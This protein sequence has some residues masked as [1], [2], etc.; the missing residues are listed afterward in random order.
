MKISPVGCSNSIKLNTKNTNCSYA[1][2]P[3]GKCGLVNDVFQKSSEISFGKKTKDAQKVL[4]R[5]GNNITGLKNE[6]EAAKACYDDPCVLEGYSSFAPCG[7]SD[8]GYQAD[9]VVVRN[10]NNA[11]KDTYVGKFACIFDTPMIINKM[12]V[13][14]DNSISADSIVLLGNNGETPGGII[15][16]NV[17]LKTKKNK[18][19]IKALDGNSVNY[20]LKADEAYA[21]DKSNDKY[22][23]GFKLTGLIDEMGVNIP[24]KLKAKCYADISGSTAVVKTDYERNLGSSE[25]YTKIDLLDLD[26]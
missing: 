17:N 22:Y 7:K 9:Q 2:N 18:H 1:T 4:M 20:I 15:L 23:T 8:I 5:Y 16:K 24:D 3:V 25:K 10:V 21:M 19:S 13:C 12:K 14:R 6:T 11:K 26:E